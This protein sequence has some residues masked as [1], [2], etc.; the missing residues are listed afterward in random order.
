M[1]AHVLHYYYRMREWR[2]KRRKKKSEDRS[3]EE[4]IRKKVLRRKWMCEGG[5][6]VTSVHC[7]VVVEQS[8][9]LLN[10][11]DAISS[12]LVNLPI[13]PLFFPK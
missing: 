9:P 2:K 5:H 4:I 12:F 7:G 3:V 11:Q 8:V 13:S 10:L 6:P 1:L